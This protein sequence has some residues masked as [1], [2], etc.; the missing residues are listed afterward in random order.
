M[1]HSLRSYDGTTKS[2]VILAI[3]VALFDDSTLAQNFLTK[4]YFISHLCLVH[5]PVQFPIPDI[6]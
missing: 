2:T 5:K 1:R 6:I 3:F 4:I